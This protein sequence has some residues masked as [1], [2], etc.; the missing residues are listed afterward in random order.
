M[1]SPLERK[2]L[3]LRQQYLPFLQRTMGYLAQKRDTAECQKINGLIEVALNLDNLHQYGEI[4]RG[5]AYSDSHNT[6]GIETVL[7]SLNLF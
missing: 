2:L 7:I 5:K 3:D 6:S 1:G 4:W